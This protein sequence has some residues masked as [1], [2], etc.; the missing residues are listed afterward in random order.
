MIPR[1]AGSEKKGA[2]RK[3]SIEHKPILEENFLKL[4]TE[5]TMG[6]PMRHGVLW[7]NLSRRARSVVVWLIGRNPGE[8]TYGSQIIE[9]ARFRAA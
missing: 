9:E 5:F 2:G 8:S 7:T 3:A 6:D 1:R 4:L